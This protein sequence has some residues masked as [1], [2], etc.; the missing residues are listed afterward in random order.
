MPGA[1]TFP[2][3]K[4]AFGDLLMEVLDQMAGVPVNRSSR[5]KNTEGSKEIVSG[6]DVSDILQSMDSTAFGTADRIR[7]SAPRAVFLLGAVQR[8]LPL[9]PSV[10]GVFSEPERRTL[11]ALELPVSDVL[12][13]RMLQE[14]TSPTPRCARLRSCIL[15]IPSV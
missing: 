11:L 13:D 12:E 1:M 5:V 7:P 9:I 4:C 2:P 10:N 3:L 14:S 6:E 15:R 8:E